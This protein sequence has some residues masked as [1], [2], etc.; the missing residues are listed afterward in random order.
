MKEKEN[1]VQVHTEIYL[2][3]KKEKKSNYEVHPAQSLGFWFSF[4]QSGTHK[5]QIN[6]DLKRDLV[7]EI[8]N[9]LFSKD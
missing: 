9:N 8:K 7:T 5:N 3:T 1:N 6:G 2:Q 4:L